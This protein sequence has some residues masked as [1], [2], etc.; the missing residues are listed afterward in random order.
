MRRG[1]VACYCRCE[2]MFNFAMRKDIQYSSRRDETDA[3]DL[4]ASFLFLVRSDMTIFV[5]LYRSNMSF[6]TRLAK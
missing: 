2:G 6:G 1:E 3:E 5:S 4:S